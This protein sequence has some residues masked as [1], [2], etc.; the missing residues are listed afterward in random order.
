MKKLIWVVV[1]WETRR[2]VRAFDDEE[3]ANDFC[4]DMY[5]IHGKDG[6]VTEVVLEEG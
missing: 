1:D 3:K 4:D 6:L 2:A 5:L